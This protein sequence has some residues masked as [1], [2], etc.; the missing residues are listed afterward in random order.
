MLVGADNSGAATVHVALGV[1]AL[2]LVAA[3]TIVGL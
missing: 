2:A 1:L 3:T